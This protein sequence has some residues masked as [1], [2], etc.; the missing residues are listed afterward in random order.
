LGNPTASVTNRTLAFSVFTGPDDTPEGIKRNIEHSRQWNAE[1]A[2]GHSHVDGV[3]EK[4]G[5]QVPGGFNVPDTQY[6]LPDLF[7]QLG[8]EEFEFPRHNRLA[9]L[10]FVGPILPQPK[11]TIKVPA[12][13]E[14]S[15]SSKPMVFVTQGTLANFDFNQLMNPA[16]AALADEDVQVIVTAGGGKCDYCSSERDRRTVSSL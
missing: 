2:R 12:W 8:A 3:L 6:R 1:R 13:L 14:E 5:A 16:I 9:N 15:N 4:L 7:L 10:R 11:D